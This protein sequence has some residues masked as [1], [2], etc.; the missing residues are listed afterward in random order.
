MPSKKPK[1]HSV[2]LLCPVCKTVIQDVNLLN[3]LKEDLDA[4]WETI[5]EN[6][7]CNSVCKYCKQP[8]GECGPVICAICQSSQNN[9]KGRKSNRKLEF[10]DDSNI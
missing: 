3:S 5:L 7:M 8:I 6:K 2:R 9:I 4:Y 10:K 1:L